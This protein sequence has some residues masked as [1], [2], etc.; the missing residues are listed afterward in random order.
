[1]LADAVYRLAGGDRPGYEYDAGGVASGCMQGPGTQS[2]AAGRRY[3]KEVRMSRVLVVLAPGAEEIETVTVA[4]VLVR[5]GCTV[6][7]AHVDAAVVDGSRGI[8]LGGH[9]PLHAVAAE[10]YDLVFLPGGKGSAEYCR[11]DA[12]VQD[13]IAAQLASGRPLAVICAAALA[14]VPRGLAQGRRITSYPGV[15]AAVADACAEWVDAPVVRDGNLI[16]SQGPGTALAL[17]LT[18]ARDLRGADVAEE[19]AAAMLV[20]MPEPV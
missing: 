13:L 12:R 1:M 16:T 4:D 8:R 18:L 17:A 5:A 3:R 14:L 19:V 7:V 15:R 20:P 6:T 10:R 9:A 11:D 2:F